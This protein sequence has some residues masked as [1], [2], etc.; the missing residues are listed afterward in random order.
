MVKNNPRYN[1]IEVNNGMHSFII[2]DRT[3]SQTKLI[4]AILGSLALQLK[5]MGY[6]HYEIHLILICTAERQGAL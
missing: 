2:G 5:A 6:E 4:H 3:H 1:W